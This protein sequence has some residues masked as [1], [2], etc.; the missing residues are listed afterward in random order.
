MDNTELCRILQ[1]VINTLYFHMDD[2]RACNPNIED[3]L[4]DAA[5]K[6]ESVITEL[7]NQDN[8]LYI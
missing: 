8:E 7:E 6:I 4:Y 1:D 5:R 3:N 2:V